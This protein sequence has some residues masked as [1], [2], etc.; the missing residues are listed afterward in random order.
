MVQ[1]SAGPPSRTA[2]PTATRALALASGSGH[3]LA[4]G[5]AH[6]LLAVSLIGLDRPA[7]ALEHCRRALATQRRAGQRLAQAGTLLTAGHAYQR[8]GKTPTA[9]SRWRQAHVL[10]TEVGAP[11]RETTATLLI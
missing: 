1:P 8:L 10:F 2:G 6:G 9:R 11:E 4:V 7:E 3:K 5:Q